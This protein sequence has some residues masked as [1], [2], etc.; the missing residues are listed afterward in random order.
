MAVCG[1]DTRKELL[2]VQLDTTTSTSASAKVTIIS[3]FDTFIEVKPSE[4]TA[5]SF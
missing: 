5:V 3:E 1:I 2:E 4:S